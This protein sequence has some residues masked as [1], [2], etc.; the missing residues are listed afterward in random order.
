MEDG[1]E[2][3]H[4]PLRW[5]SEVGT[6]LAQQ[7]QRDEHVVK[8]K[9]QARERLRHQ[10]V[11]ELRLKIYAPEEGRG[12]DMFW[13]MLPPKEYEPYRF[14][15]EQ[16]REIFMRALDDARRQLGGENLHRTHPD[17]A[18][19]PTCVF[20]GKSEKDGIRIVARGGGLFA[21]ALCA[22]CRTHITP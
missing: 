22:E 8:K 3:E 12:A 1:R 14:T 5:V 2:M 9:E 21:P 20:C 4:R 15:V 6:T 17:P 16:W 19:F 11:A 13:D 10:P 7:A 18:G